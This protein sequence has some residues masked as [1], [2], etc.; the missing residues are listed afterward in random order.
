MAYS[1]VLK[2]NK[3]P[4]LPQELICD[5][6][7]ALLG[8]WFLLFFDGSGLRAITAAKRNAFYLLSGLL[9][10][11]L[12]GSLLIGRLRQPG[13]R[14]V[15]RQRVRRASPMLWC[16]LAYLGVTL[17]SALVSRHTAEVWLGASRKEGFV[18]QLFYVLDF[19]AILL[20]ARPKKLLLYVFG[21]GMSV[22]CM[23]C[24]LHLLRLDPLALFPETLDYYLTEERYL[25][26]V[27]NVGFIGALLCL[28]IPVFSAGVLLLK[29]RLRWLL[30]IPL[31][32]CVILLFCISVLAAYVGL[33]LGGLIVTPFVLR[34]S[35][36]RI[37]IWFFAVG[38]GL[39]S[40]L[41]AVF[42]FDFGGVLH[43][44]HELL[45]LRFSDSFGSGRFF[46]WR[47]TLSRIPAHFLFGTGPDTMLLEGFEPFTRYDPVTHAMTRMASIDAAHN[48]YLNILFHQGIFALLAYGAA[49][50]YAWRSFFRFARRSAPAAILGAAV[51][52]CSIEALFGISQPVTSPFFWAALGLLGA[53]CRGKTGPTEQENALVAAA[54]D[55][56]QAASAADSDI[57]PEI[58][59]N[60][61]E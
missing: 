36:R 50:V 55:A 23:I 17:I 43:E 37:R 46:I 15:L 48:E 2:R 8:T 9:L 51:I 19:S 54:A 33:V 11:S 27:G 32:F 59:K 5:V 20:F 14:D 40:A 35:G 49:I 44:L 26:T 3:D 10:L 24:F 22:F 52:C 12:A 57:F 47:Q 29:D 61:Q 25:G 28:A 21:L 30:L 42:L 38:C 41:I 53:A 18:T 13:M 34:F 7:L 4:L 39:L 58:E 6:F 45:H 16:M 56:L 1:L 31:A 60:V